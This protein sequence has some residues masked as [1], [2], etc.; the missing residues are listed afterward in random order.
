[1]KTSD[2]KHL[3]LL[4][5][6]V[7]QYPGEHPTNM[8]GEINYNVI[9]IRLPKDE[10]YPNIRKMRIVNGWFFSKVYV[11]VDESSESKTLERHKLRLTNK[12]I[13]QVFKKAAIMAHANMNRLEIEAE[14]KRRDLLDK[15]IDKVIQQ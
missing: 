7:H 3:L 8:T 15:A 12:D 14:L 10:T 6:V 13:R 11:H 2:E 1:M 5:T 4:E 9:D